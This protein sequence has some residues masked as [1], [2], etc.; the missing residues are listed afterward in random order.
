MSEADKTDLELVL[1]Y[2]K[3]TP[4]SF[5]GWGYGPAGRYGD[6]LLLYFRDGYT[7]HI[8]RPKSL[9]Y[10]D[11]NAMGMKTLKVSENK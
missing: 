9:V 7:L 3:N 5:R 8:H 4:D 10:K 2:L 1:D 11:G 6:D